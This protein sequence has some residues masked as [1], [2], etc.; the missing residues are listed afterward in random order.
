M[1]GYIAIALFVLSGVTLFFGRRKMVLAVYRKS[2]DGYFYNYKIGR[3]C[4]GLGKGAIFTVKRVS[5]FEPLSNSIFKL[6]QLACQKCY[7]FGIYPFK[8]EG[9]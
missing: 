5:Y 9:L 2:P 8:V 6:E 3:A 1:L 4:I 7:K